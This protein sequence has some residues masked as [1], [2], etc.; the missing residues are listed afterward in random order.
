VTKDQRDIVAEIRALARAQGLVVQVN[1]SRGKGSHVRVYIGSHVA[2]VPAKVKIG[3]R[4]AI[5]KQLGL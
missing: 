2:T 1:P 5:L 4:R 3:T